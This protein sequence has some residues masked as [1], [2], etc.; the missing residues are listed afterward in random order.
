MDMQERIFAGIFS[1]GIFYAD[2][3]REEHG[4]WKRLANVN[5]RTLQ[6]EIEPDCPPELRDWIKQDAEKI[7]TRRGQEFRI[8]TAGQTITLGQ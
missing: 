8:S 3:T 1:T 6:L 7:Q 5:F 4:D 2:R